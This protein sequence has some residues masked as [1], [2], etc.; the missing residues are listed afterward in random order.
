MNGW[1]AL[2]AYK[3][4]EIFS[5]IYISSV[6]SPDD[7]QYSTDGANPNV[8]RGNLSP[9][10][11]L[12]NRGLL[13]KN[14]STAWSLL[15]WGLKLARQVPRVVNYKK[16]LVV[17]A[18]GRMDILHKNTLTCLLSSVELAVQSITTLAPSM[19]RLSRSP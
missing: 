6:F 19:R 5:M 13:S 4:H 9:Y 7:V 16:I 10:M 8:H 15:D 18:M 3:W 17:N 11:F 12:A 14:N 2:G 1:L